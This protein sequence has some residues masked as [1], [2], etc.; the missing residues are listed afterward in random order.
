VQNDSESHFPNSMSKGI[1]IA[2]ACLYTF[3]NG[4]EKE[5]KKPKKLQN[6]N[7]CN[8]LNRLEHRQKFNQS[9]QNCI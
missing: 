1:V 6:Y 2:V 3:P 8:S 5:R 7:L 9:K 4:N